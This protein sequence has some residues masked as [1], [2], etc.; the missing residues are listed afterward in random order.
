MDVSESL[1]VPKLEDGALHR[2]IA[3][4][5]TRSPAEACGL[6]LIDESSPDQRVIELANR[7]MRPHTSYEFTGDDA[8][9]AL[10]NNGVEGWN[11]IEVAVWHTHPG[12]SIGPST[13]DLTQKLEGVPHLVVALLDDGTTM[14][15]WF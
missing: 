11:Y 3:I 5:R 8:Y 10:T 2:I 13:E 4:G 1:S 14:H 15:E 12:G 9:I 7:S 6:L